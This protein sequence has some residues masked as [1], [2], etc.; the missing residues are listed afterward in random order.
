MCI[1]VLSTGAHPRWRLVVAANRDEYHARAAAPLGR[2]SDRPGII[3]GRDLAGGGTWL[4][5]H[6]QGRLVLVTNYRVPGYPQ[7][8]RPSR[9]GLVTGLLEGGDPAEVAVGEYNPFTL[10]HV[11]AGGATLLCNYPQPSRRRLE[12][13]VHGVSN[14]PFDPPWPKTMRLWQRFERWLAAEAEDPEPLFAALADDSGTEVTAQGPE[15]RFSGVFV[16]DPDYGTRCST[17]VMVDHAGRG[18]I[19]ER[20]FDNAA[21]ETGTSE[22]RFAWP[23]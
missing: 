7:P 2:W 13:G 10:I 18:T 11:D 9:G 16:R 5:V 23:A 1:A 22:E 17:I 20:R 14:G 6:E 12:P 8:G 19:I 3:A 15:A 4:G 21:R